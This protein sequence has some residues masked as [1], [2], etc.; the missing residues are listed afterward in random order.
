MIMNKFLKISTL[1]LLVFLGSCKN[2]EP[3]VLDDSAQLALD[4][5]PDKGI[6]VA[7]YNKGYIDDF[8]GEI[9]MW[10][11]ANDKVAL[12]K[13][14]DTL[15]VTLK[16][17]GSKYECW[18]REFSM[19]DFSESPV[20]KVRAR[21]EGATIPTI[22][23]SLKDV[24]AYDAN[25]NPPSFR[26]KKGGFQDYYFNF[27]DK[28]KQGWPDEKIVDV[29]TIREILFFVN[30]GAADWTGTLY[31]DEIKAVKVEDIPAKKT[32]STTVTSDPNT[33]NNNTTTTTT[34]TTTTTTTTITTPEKSGVEMI[35]DFSTEIYSWWAGNDK[36]KLVK[37]EEMLKVELKG[38][39]PGYET[40][41]R[42]FKP[43]DFTKTPVVKVKMKASGEKP[44]M[45]RV[46]IKDADGFATNSKPNVI[47]FE[48]GTNFVDYYYDFT[49]KFE[50]NWPNVKTVNPSEI[51]EVLFFVNP[52][53]E[54][55][56]GTIMIDE[57][58]AI[59]LDDYKNK[60]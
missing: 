12:L 43:I 57:I 26:L 40:W 25:F 52:G 36:V 27:K 20:I 3:K 16:Q 7:K 1:A 55:Y 60:K 59:S 58:S 19:C 33:T 38:V 45:L 21:Y 34:E 9:N 29:T 51:I 15:R 53:G 48:P 5:L 30:P 31:I 14:G 18:G 22:R 11:V 44:A 24:N 42:G 47:K 37:E 32:S 50:Q 4:E 28:W 54:L 2:F 23:L 41:G 49:G 46:D 56:S 17:A 10:W 13:T 8:S 6:P 35:D 39:G